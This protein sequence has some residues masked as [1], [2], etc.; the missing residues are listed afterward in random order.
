MARARLEDHPAWCHG[1]HV[2]SESSQRPGPPPPAPQ[3]DTLPPQLYPWLPLFGAAAYLLAQV[4]LTSLAPGA[5]D[6]FWEHAVVGAACG[7]LSI[8]AVLSQ[9]VRHNFA[10][11]NLWSAFLV[12]GHF[13]SLVVRNNVHEIY[14]MGWV[15]AVAATVSALGSRRLM[16]IF[17]AYVLAAWALGAT[18]VPPGRGQAMVFVLL[19][20]AVAGLLVYVNAAGRLQGAS[21]AYERGAKRAVF[22]SIEEGL[23]VHARD[24][25]LLHHNNAALDLLGFTAQRLETSRPETLLLD[26]LA[27]GQPNPTVRALEEG[28]PQPPQAL[29]LPAALAHRSVEATAVPYRDPNQ[30][31]G[32][33][34]LLRDVTP[35]RQLEQHLRTA[36]RLN[37]L[38]TL[39]AGVAHEINNPLAYIIGNLQFALEVLEGKRGVT[40]EARDEIPG[41]LREALQ[42]AERVRRIVADLGVFSR[43]GETGAVSN[44]DVRQAVGAALSLTNHELKH[45]CQVVRHDAEVPA[46]LVHEGRLVQVLVNL[47]INAAHAM[48]VGEADKHT[49]EVTTALLPEGQVAV[50]IRDNGCG[51]PLDIQPRVFDPF[52]TTKTVGE[53]TGLGLSICH[54]LIKQMGGDIQLQSQPGVGT[55]VTLRLPSVRRAAAGSSLPRDPDTMPRL[56]VLLLD[57]DAL[58]LRAMGRGLGTRHDVTTTTSARE[59]L[60][61][62][63]ADPESFDAVVCDVMM[64]DMSG[65]EFHRALQ[66]RVPRLTRRVVFLTGGA[67]SEDA[68][69][70][71]AQV[72]LPVVEKPFDD[73]TMENALR[74]VTVATSPLRRATPPAR[75]QS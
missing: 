9:R 43:Q 25:Q 14:A 4:I 41:A 16:H 12:I 40:Q 6:P 58:V 69:T 57:D 33:V 23:V 52:F 27:P 39:A 37:S 55:T 66:T 32:V 71:L 45:R 11:L 61:L 31:L 7:A 54:S 53:G 75:A 29:L 35:R 21:R 59:A 26:L 36:D 44:V 62:L 20:S 60:D 22:D 30:V 2:P 38:G 42:G 17:A 18:M 28:V 19:A 8:G 48:P 73:D 49:V 24:G 68:R 34:T 3:N 13:L 47:L 46:I 74:T 72:K 1:V 50:T 51:I 15:T 67:F 5:A 64:P 10:W 70:F 65:M 63:A 56:R